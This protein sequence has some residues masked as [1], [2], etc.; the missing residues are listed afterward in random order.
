MLSPS[1]LRIRPP[2]PLWERSDRIDRCD[3]GEGLRP[4]DRPEPLTPTLSHKGGGSATPLLLQINLQPALRQEITSPK[5]RAS[6]RQIFAGLR[7]IPDARYSELPRR[8]RPAFW[9]PAPWRVRRSGPSSAVTP[10]ARSAGPA[11]CG[12]RRP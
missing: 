11:R 5:S 8:G 10:L 7:E 1:V 9:P 12:R 2:L 4:I 6:T 3:P